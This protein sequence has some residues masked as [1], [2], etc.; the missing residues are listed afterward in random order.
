MAEVVVPVSAVVPSVGVAQVIATIMVDYGRTMQRLA[1]D[2]AAVRR[3]V[4]VG[5]AI[6]ECYPDAMRGLAL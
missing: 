4:E 6:I 2:D 5:Q 1:A 3:Q